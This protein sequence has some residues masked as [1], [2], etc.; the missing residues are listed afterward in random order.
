VTAEQV[1]K[2][3]NART[4]QGGSVTIRVDAGKVAVGGAQVLATDVGASNGLIHVIDTVLLP[5]AAL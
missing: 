1:A 5:P 2:L 4:A 3:D